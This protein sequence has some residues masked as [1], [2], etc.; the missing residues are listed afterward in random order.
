MSTL[1][2]FVREG[3]RL[4]AALWNAL[5]TAVRACRILPGN[6][7]RIRQTPDGTLLSCTL[8]DDWNHPFKVISAGDTA[9]IAK[10]T[11]DGIEPTIDD[12]P[13]SGDAKKKKPVPLLDL[14]NPKFDDDGHGWVAIEITCD[15]LKWKT[16]KAEIKQVDDLTDQDQ[17]KARH[18]IAL[19]T[20]NANGSLNTFQIE[21]FN[22]QHRADG[23][24]GVPTRHFFWPA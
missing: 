10:G 9:T 18:P 11:V 5:V 23:L 14:S 22:L 4:T 1:S 13:I 19:L 24:T 15:P 17:L 6:G 12:V 3:D 20:Q 16:M 2:L 8:W 21:F 7:V